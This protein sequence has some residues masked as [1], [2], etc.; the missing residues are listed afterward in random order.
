VSSIPLAE[1]GGLCTN[2]YICILPKCQRDIVDASEL[3]RETPINCLL[4]GLRFSSF[5]SNPSVGERRT[6]GFAFSH[7]NGVISVVLHSRS[8]QILVVGV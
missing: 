3:L 7:Q 1:A 2:I 8:E 6:G 4:S 5:A